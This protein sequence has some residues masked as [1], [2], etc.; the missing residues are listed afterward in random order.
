[1]IYQLKCQAGSNIR[2]KN[3]PMLIK[4]ILLVACST[5][6]VPSPFNHKIWKITIFPYFFQKQFTI[7]IL[8]LKLDIERNNSPFNLN[9]NSYVVSILP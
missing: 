5:S 3:K 7:G 4:F 9:L 1:M 2:Y 6:G 8:N